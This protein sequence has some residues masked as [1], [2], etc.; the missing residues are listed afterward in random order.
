MGR[1]LSLRANRLIDTDV[2]SASFARLLSA[3]HRRRW[4][5]SEDILRIPSQT[6]NATV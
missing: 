6:N 1:L 5:S 4:A 3:G 2:L